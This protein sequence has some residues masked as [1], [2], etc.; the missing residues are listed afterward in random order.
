MPIIISWPPGQL[1]FVSRQ[2]S[3]FPSRHRP[4][5]RCEEREAVGA[6]PRDRR[7]TCAKVSTRCPIGQGRLRI[8]FSAL[9]RCQHVDAGC[10]LRLPPQLA[11]ATVRQPPANPDDAAARHSSS[12]APSC[13]RPP[14]DCPVPSPDRQ[15]FP[16]RPSSGHTWNG[17]WLGRPSAGRRSGS[18]LAS[19]G[20]PRRIGIPSRTSPFPRPWPPLPPARP[21]FPIIPARLLTVLDC[22]NPRHPRQPLISHPAPSEGLPAG[23][24]PDRK[25]AQKVGQAHGCQKSPV[26]HVVAD[27]PLPLFQQGAAPPAPTDDRLASSV[28]H[29]L[30]APEHT[31]A[32]YISKL[33]DSQTS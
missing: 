13:I 7:R 15:G 17:R 3:T 20:R 6:K 28:A 12:Q 18:C 29:A 5:G 31:P 16:A 1:S 25:T 24:A 14:P 27:R 2:T 11:P 4:V 10:T 32:R 22:A 23:L 21:A 8:A 19:L 9:A 30:L 33:D 26:S